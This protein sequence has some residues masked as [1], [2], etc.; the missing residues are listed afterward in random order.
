MVLRSGVNLGRGEIIDYVSSV[1]D[2]SVQLSRRDGR[3]AV[4]HL[5]LHRA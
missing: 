3:R 1:I 4:S 2:V 5:A